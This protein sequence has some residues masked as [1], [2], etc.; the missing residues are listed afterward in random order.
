M[1]LFVERLK[2]LIGETGKQ[3]IEICKEL[4]IKKQ[5]LSNWKTG[6]SEPNIDDIIM[7]ANYFNCTIDYLVG[8][9]KD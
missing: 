5:V 7:L 2:E 6:Y 3:Q 9:E 8:R 1:N 4:N